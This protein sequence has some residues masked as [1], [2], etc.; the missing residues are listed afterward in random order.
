MLVG[1]RLAGT[2]CRTVVP[3][4]W[5]GLQAVR[6][7]VRGRL[8]AAV[9]RRA[10]WPSASPEYGSGRHAAAHGQA[11]MWLRD[12]RSAASHR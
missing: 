2:R 5:G 3:P 8:A 4:L 11:S 10:C 7:P 6:G 12:G 9:N 1:L